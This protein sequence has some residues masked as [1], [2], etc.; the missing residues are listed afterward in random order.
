VAEDF[1][2]K[3][4]ALLCHSSQTQNTMAGAGTS[5]SARAAFVERMK[6]WAEDQGR[7]AGLTQAES[8]KLIRP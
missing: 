7:A 1:E 2:A 5:E 6:S 4:E 8:F 3:I